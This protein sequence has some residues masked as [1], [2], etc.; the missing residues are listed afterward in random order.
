MNEVAFQ[1][2]TGQ[3][4]ISNLSGLQL[5]FF[6]DSF[7]LFVGQNF[8]LWV[9]KL[10]F[11]KA[12]RA[13]EGW[14]LG[15]RFGVSVQLAAERGFFC[16]GH[17]FLSLCLHWEPFFLLSLKWGIQLNDGEHPSWKEPTPERCWRRNFPMQTKREITIELLIY[18]LKK[19]SELRQELL[20][21]SIASCAV[22]LL[23]FPLL[24]HPLLFGVEGVV[25]HF[26]KKWQ[27]IP[28]TR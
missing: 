9:I 15:K 8:S 12:G 13:V 21:W 5:L 19:V 18:D 10:N 14:N 16:S 23:V 22:P 26:H 24:P 20:C 25:F 7:V 11:S 4:L 27:Q 3:L 1:N 17:V 28:Q 6:W 2:L